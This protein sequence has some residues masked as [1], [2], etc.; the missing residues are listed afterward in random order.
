MCTFCSK[1]CG[2][3]TFVS[4]P[5]E[6]QSHYFY[7]LK[8]ELIKDQWCPEAACGSSNQRCLTTEIENI[9]KTRRPLDWEGSNTNHSSLCG[10]IQG[11]CRFLR[12]SN[13]RHKISAFPLKTNLSCA[14]SL[15]LIQLFPT[16]WTVAHLAPLSTGFP[17]QEYWS[18]FQFPFIGNLSNPGIKLASPAL[19]ADSLPAEPLW[20]P[21]T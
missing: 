3:H 9:N 6:E 5:P 21:K 10:Q 17:M 14:W 13:H 1:A 8:M 19:Q 18:G 12:L 2:G 4:L 16:P 20:K 11:P 15:S 7:T